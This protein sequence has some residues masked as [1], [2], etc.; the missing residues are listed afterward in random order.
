MR[1]ESNFL[2]LHNTR[3]EASGTS[4]AMLPSQYQV[5]RRS[6]SE[7]EYDDGGFGNRPS[8]GG[9]ASH[10]RPVGMQQPPLGLTGVICDSKTIAI[11]N[12]GSLHYTVFRPRHLRIKPP[13]VCIAGG[14]LLPCIYLQPLVHQITDRSV[15]FFDAIGCGQSKLLLGHAPKERSHIPPVSAANIPDMVNDFA[16][17]MRHL[18]VKD[19]HLL[20][21]SFGGIIA[22]EW[23]KSHQAKLKQEPKANFCGS[24]ILVSTPVSISAAMQ[25]SVN[26]QDALREEHAGSSSIDVDN[27]SEVMAEFARIHECRLDPLPLPLQQAFMGVFFSASKGLAAVQHYNALQPDTRISSTDDSNIGFPETLIIRGE[28]DFVSTECQCDWVDILGSDVQFE[29]VGNSAHYSMLENEDEFAEIV[30]RFLPDP[31]EED[32]IVLP[33]GVKVRR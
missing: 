33:N 13:L 6:G 28:Y 22:Y 8:R 23:A 32:M 29:T 3:T 18:K 4:V 19:F 31:P 5:R 20:G 7:D 26:L 16:L 1:E 14:P 30:R 11:P 15:I 24:L 9:L 27:T 2:S 21:H 12:R 10:Q 17:L 25:N